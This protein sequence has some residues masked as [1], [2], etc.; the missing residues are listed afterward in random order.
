[1]KIQAKDELHLVGYR[2]TA[3]IAEL[4][5][6]V[7]EANERMLARL[8]EVDGRADEYLL[9]VALGVEN[10][11]YTQFV[12]VEVDP[13]AEAPGEMEKLEMSAARW[14]HFAHHGPAEEIGN[15]IGTMRQWADHND[16]PTEH[17]FVISRPLD[18]DGPIDLL[19]RLS[20]VDP[21]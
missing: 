21:E 7:P 3:P 17:V 5:T 13:D 10:G 19:V 9:S 4:S 6:K 18:G 11:S 16:Q 15:S 20:D 12:G 1:M 8:D 2:I 14:V